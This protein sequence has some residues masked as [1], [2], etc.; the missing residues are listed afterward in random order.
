MT[1]HLQATVLDGDGALLA[2]GVHLDDAGTVLALDAPS[3]PSSS[4]A[5]GPVIVP[6][7]VDVHCHGGGGVSFPDAPSLDAVLRAAETHARGGTL[8]LLGSLVSLREP[9]P[10]IDALADAC[11]ADALA[12]IHLEGPFLS[13]ARC[14]AQDPTAVRPI[15][16]AELSAMLEAGRGWVRSMTLAPEIEHALDAAEMLH[17]AGARPSWGHTDATADQTA[18]VLSEMT[19][20]GIG[21]TV[22]HLFNAMPSLHHRRPGPVLE[23]LAA[24]TRGE[25][26]VE[27]IGDGVHLDP[28]LVR[29]LIISLDPSAGVAL[30]SDAMA[31]AGIVD[32]HYRLGELEVTMRDGAAYLIGTDTLAG[33]TSTLGDQVHRLLAEGIPAPMLARAACGTPARALGLPSPVPATV[34]RPF[35]GVLLDTGNA[36]VWRRGSELTGSVQ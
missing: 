29:E 23:F 8:T 19:A 11:D 14:G 22:T 26:V 17:A 25:A 15:D 35:S 21:Q 6:G 34:G 1:E 33:G 27:V 7:F 4:D 2:D 20:R 32:G 9:V 18:A 30:V 3:D 10:V 36:R 13:P 31:A 5:A 28:H 12:G 16:L 24:A